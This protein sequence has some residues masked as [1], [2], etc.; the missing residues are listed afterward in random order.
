MIDQNT[1]TETLR[2]VQEIIRTSA[3]PMTREEILSYFKDM[4]LDSQQEAMVFEFL[5]VPHEEEE[6]VVDEADPE[7]G[8]DETK[9]DAPQPDP[10]SDS[11]VFQMYL[12]ELKDLPKYSKEQLEEMYKKLLAGEETMVQALSNAWL[13]GVLEVAKKLALSPEGLPD[14]VQEGNMALFLRLGELCGSRESVDVEEELLTAAEEAMKACIR[15][16]TGEDEQENSVVG[17]VALVNEAVKY[18]KDQNGHEPSIKEIEEYTRIPGEELAD[19][20]QLI[21]KAKKPS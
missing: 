1:F 15:E 9:K 18:L 2:A 6:T 19:L 8:E 16:Q 21:Q 17:K 7:Q 10:I 11:P 5:T 13:P 12:E 3:Q 20:L 14:I 4:E